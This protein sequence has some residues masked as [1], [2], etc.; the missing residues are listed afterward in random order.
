M[1]VFERILW[2]VFLRK[3]RHVS[4]H[5]FLL[6]VEAWSF[7]GQFLLSLKKK[8]EE[9]RSFR[10]KEKKESYPEKEEVQRL[11]LRQENL[12]SFFLSFSLDAERLSSRSRR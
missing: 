2:F 12:L 9:E 8:R 4:F 1:K 10:K 3:F 11:F 7:R 5:P 6:T